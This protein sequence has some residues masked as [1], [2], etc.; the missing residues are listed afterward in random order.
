MVLSSFNIVIIMNNQVT[1]SDKASYLPCRVAA[2]SRCQDYLPSRSHW[3]F[4]II[5]HHIILIVFHC[6]ICLLVIMHLIFI[7]CIIVIVGIHVY[8]HVSFI[9]C[10]NICI[11]IHIGNCPTKEIL[12]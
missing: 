1:V 5:R 12:V 11:I 9:W 6:P 3:I 7:L 8:C 2:T 4:M 10:C